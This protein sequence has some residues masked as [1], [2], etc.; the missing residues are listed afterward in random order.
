MAALGHHQPVRQASD[1]DFRQDGIG[2][3]IDHVEQPALDIGYI[4]PAGLLIDHD[5]V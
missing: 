4:D 3:G 5:R 1:G 2:A